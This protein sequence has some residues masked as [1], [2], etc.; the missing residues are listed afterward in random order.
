MP[1]PSFFLENIPRTERLDDFKMSMVF[2]ESSLEMLD[3]LFILTFLFTLRNHCPAASS[4]HKASSL[5][6]Q[7]FCGLLGEFRS[8]PN[9]DLNDP[10]QA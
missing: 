3:F 4:S 7:P 9:S 5:A 6:L 10:M 8:N 2:K 1:L